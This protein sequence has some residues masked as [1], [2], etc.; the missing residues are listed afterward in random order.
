LSLFFSAQAEKSAAYT[1]SFAATNGNFA[2]LAKMVLSGERVFLS[3]AANS[4]AKA[5]MFAAL[6]INSP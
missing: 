1:E 5:G 2:T 4:P 3:R 6:A